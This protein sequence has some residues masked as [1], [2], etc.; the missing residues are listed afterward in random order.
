ML[1]VNVH[2]LNCT[3]HPETV[4]AITSIELGIGC[5]PIPLFPESVT[6]SYGTATEIYNVMTF[7]FYISG[8]IM[9]S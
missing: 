3:L 7:I 4:R 5:Y 9:S 1:C 6:L 8:L 2:L